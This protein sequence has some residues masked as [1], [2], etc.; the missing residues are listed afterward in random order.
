MKIDAPKE[1]VQKNIDTA[2]LLLANR[3]DLRMG[4]ECVQA[5]LMLLRDGET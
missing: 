5:D 3:A 4:A 1:K 2:R